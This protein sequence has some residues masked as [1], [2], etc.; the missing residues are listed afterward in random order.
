V[1]RASLLGNPLTPDGRPIDR[2]RRN[3]AATL[4][5]LICSADAL[6]P[7][8]LLDQPPTAKAPRLPRHPHAGRCQSAACA[9]SGWL[10]GPKARP[11]FVAAP[12]RQRW[13]RAAGTGLRTPNPETP[14]APGQPG[15]RVMV[16]TSVRRL[17]RRQYAE[18]GSSI[19]LPAPPGPTHTRI[20]CPQP[21]VS[22]RSL[23]PRPE[24]HGHAGP[25]ASPAATGCGRARWLACEDGRWLRRSR[26]VLRIES[27]P[28]PS[29]ASRRAP[30][31]VSSTCAGRTMSAPS[32]SDCICMRDWLAVAR[33]PRASWS[34]ATRV[35]FHGATIST[36][37]WGYGLQ[38]RA[39]DMR[40]PRARVRPRIARALPGASGARPAGQGRHEVTPPC[41]G[42]DAAS[43]SL[44]AACRNDAQARPATTE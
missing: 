13:F 32:R 36:F 19:V 17:A 37:Y 15:R 3:N 16:H 24:S 34:H 41:S 4:F 7:S 30:S 31:A 38:G 44:S 40:R 12:E 2:R 22:S 8:S 25:M 39:C 23:S 26:R 20:S 10:R 29:A 21:G 5:L 27:R 28:T 1:L 42:T 11:L 6:R 33:R 14:S 9:A 43:P 35:L 18:R